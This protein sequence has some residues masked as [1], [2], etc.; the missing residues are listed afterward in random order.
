MSESSNKLTKE[1]ALNQAIIRCINTSE[2]LPVSSQTIFDNLKQENGLDIL[3]LYEA[4]QKL[5]INHILKRTM[6]NNKPF[7]S[8]NKPAIPAPQQTQSCIPRGYDMDS[9]NPNLFKINK[10]NFT[11]LWLDYFKHVL[12]SI[13]HDLLGYHSKDVF[14]VE[15]H[16]FLRL[17]DFSAQ[18]YQNHNPNISYYDEHVMRYSGIQD[19]RAMYHSLLHES[20][21]AACEAMRSI[22]WNFEFK[23]KENCIKI[24]SIHFTPK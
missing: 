14:I 18:I 24:E 16:G 8:L 9:L 22:G 11:M 12:N 2:V 23:Y 1:H 6:I 10:E 20:L 17:I 3:D 7:F 5:V 21:V 19:R 15:V 4:L 13:R